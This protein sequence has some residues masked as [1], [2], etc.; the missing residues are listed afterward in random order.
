MPIVGEASAKYRDL[1]LFIFAFIAIGVFLGSFIAIPLLIGDKKTLKGIGVGAAST[2]GYFLIDAIFTYGEKLGVSNA[3]YQFLIPAT[4][5]STVISFFIIIAVIFHINKKDTAKYKLSIMDI[6]SGNK[7]AFDNYSKSKMMQIEAD[8]KSK[9]NIEKLENRERDVSRK[10]RELEQKHTDLECKYEKLSEIKDEVDSIADKSHSLT[11]PLTFQ[12]L[13][14]KDFLDLLPRYVDTVAKFSHHTSIMTQDIIK[15][16]EKTGLDKNKAVRL[17]FDTLCTYIGE[18]LF[19]WR[20]IRV[21]ARILNKDSDKYEKIAAYHKK[22]EIY[23]NNITPIGVT[24]GLIAKSIREKRSLV[25]SANS[26]E[27]KLTDNSH[28]WCDFMTIAVDKPVVHNRPLFT[29][30]ISVKYPK[31]HQAMMYFLSYIKIEQL[32]QDQIMQFE[33]V[34]NFAKFIEDVA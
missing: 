9:L 28:I 33:S 17:Y 34:V 25:Y 18:Y 16:V 24:E 2:G 6:F 7:T 19:E 3:D 10:E 11:I 32:I 31:D 13:L 4:L 15:H 8:L 23:E 1:F 22:A 29:L 5:F 14:K 30:G 12:Y 26:E 20:D 21:H 27:A